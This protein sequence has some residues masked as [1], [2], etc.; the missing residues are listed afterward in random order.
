M[1]SED[2][3]HAVRSAVLR[4]AEDDPWI[5]GAAVT[6]SHA[7]GTADGWSDVDLFFAVA[8][9]C[10]VTEAL[11]AWTVGLDDA[12]GVAHHFDLA[13]DTAV[14]RAFL[15]TD[16]LEIDIGFAEQQYFAAM[17]DQAFMVDFG[18]PHHPRPAHPPDRRSAI[19]HAWHHILHAR[20][21]VVRDRPLQA[22][23]WTNAVRAIV[24][25]MMCQ[26]LGLAATHAK[27]A[28]ELPSRLQDRLAAT[29]VPTLN[30]DAF[31]VALTRI[32]DCLI[33]EL[34]L[35]NDRSY[36]PLIE[37][38]GGMRRIDHSPLDQRPPT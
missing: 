5:V 24:S 17:G 11:D 20:V 16:L 36:L 10:D 25:D 12:F 38:L 14:Y 29:I 7:R 30:A 3:Q 19:G 6:G 33:D 28:D 23:Y 13:T 18:S 1:A 21:C 34:R 15:L 4:M 35:A 32:T 9:S 27:G 26:R 22:L 8:Q 2:R 31:D 37:A